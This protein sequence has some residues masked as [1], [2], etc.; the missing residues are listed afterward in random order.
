[1]INLLNHKI[2]F[3]TQ[4]NVG[5]SDQLYNLKEQD[6]S[7]S[8]NNL[9]IDLEDLGIR[10]D[11]TGTQTISIYVGNNSL[12]NSQ[13]QINVS[14]GFD[15]DLVPKLVFVSWPTAFSIKTNEAVGQVNWN[16]GDGSGDQV[17]NKDLTHTYTR[18]GMYNVIVTLSS[19]GI[20]MTKEFPVSVGYLN[21]SILIIKNT[22]EN[23]ISSIKNFTS[24]L[25]EKVR[26]RLDERLNISNNEEEYARYLVLLAS[27]TNDS[28]KVE[29]LNNIVGLNIPDFVGFDKTEIAPLAEGFNS[30]NTEY[31]ENISDISVTEDKRDELRN[32]IIY[33]NNQNYDSQITK[34]E[35]VMNNNGNVETI[36]NFY[37]LALNK[38]GNSNIYSYLIIDYPKDEII[39]LQDYSP[40]SLVNEGSSATYI[41]ANEIN[42][43]DFFIEDEIDIKNGIIYISPLLNELGNYSQI[44]EVKT[45]LPIWWLIFWIAILFLVFFVVYILLQEWYKK[46]YEIYLFKNKDDL[47]NLLTFLANSRQVGIGDSDIKKKLSSMRWNSEQINY[48]FKVIDG[49][50]TGMWEIPIFRMKEQH[51]IK[52]EIAKRSANRLDARFIKRPFI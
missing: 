37:Y 10:L 44:E 23:K 14:K 22:T 34:R 11:N 45:P 42:N 51:K 15:I 16:F 32:N 19:K 38:K 35:V 18:P 24:S 43:L 40:S 2:I 39:F 52:Q 36:G 41:V 33:W 27:S 31:I 26:I 20:T 3:S 8:A 7:I 1:M 25:P 29:I 17:S 30:I 47:Y 6:A 50:R 9:T 21:Q 12:L 5:E 13:I 48:V 49:K 4:R 28:E 46:N